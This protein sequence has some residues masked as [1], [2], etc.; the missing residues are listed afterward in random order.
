MDKEIEKRVAREI[1]IKK[2]NTMIGNET[3]FRGT[4]VVE[5]AIR[6]DGMYEG[7]IKTKDLVIVGSTGKVKGDIYGETVVI[8]GAVKGNIFAMKN[9][10]LL[11]TAKVIGDLTATKI[12]MD[13]GA[14]FKGKFKRAN[15]EELKT[16]F[17]EEVNTFIEKEKS[18]W[19]W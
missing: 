5:G 11:S 14:K 1:N 15:E 6:I 12:L 4:F 8:G 17:D 3:I 7:N 16:I 9:I 19:E 18:S 10:V 13:E 2:V